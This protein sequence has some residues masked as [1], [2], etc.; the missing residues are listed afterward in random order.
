MKIHF[1]SLSSLLLYP[2]KEEWIIKKSTL[3]FSCEHASN[4]IPKRY[5]RLFLKK[6]NLL[7][8][9]R[10]FDNGSRQLGASLG[11]FFKS[12]VIYGQ[13]SRLLIDLNRSAH[14]RNAFSE[15]TAFLTKNEKE[16]LIKNYH[17]PHWNK[18]QGALSE[19]WKVNT[20]IIHIGVHSFTPILNNQKRNAD[21][22]IL[23]DPS[24]K[25]ERELA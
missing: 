18:V 20:L 5:K 19:L 14:H 9:H 8:T 4:A 17:T 10:G 22:G 23:Y 15:F 13:F 2:F 12:P 25:K 6:I 1:H 11:L 3:L 24:R 7:N 21:I 16:D